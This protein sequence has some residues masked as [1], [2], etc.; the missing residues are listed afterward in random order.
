MIGYRFVRV[1]AA[2][3]VCATAIPAPA[4]SIN[5]DFD[6]ASG[7]GAGVPNAA[8]GGAAS[9]SGL[10]NSIVFTFTNPGPFALAD[11]S[12]APTTATVTQSGLIGSINFSQSATNGNYKLLID[13]AVFATAA[14]TLRIDGLQ[15]GQYTVY[16]YAISPTGSGGFER[17]GIS[18]TGSA[19][20]SPQSIGGPIP[21]GT[22]ANGLTHAIHNVYVAAGSPL[23]I[24]ASPWGGNGYINGM[25][26]V[27]AI[28]A[29]SDI[30]YPVEGSCV[31]GTVNVSGTAS[32]IASYSL[33]Y[34]TQLS[35]P[36]FAISSRTT[37]VTNATLGT[38]NTA[39]LDEGTYYLR[40][41]TVTPNG[42]SSTLVR[43]VVVTR[44]LPT[45][46]LASPK[47]NAV[48]GGRVPVSGSANDICLASYQ[49][50]YIDVEGLPT[51]HV[52]DPAAP[53]S[54]ASVSGGVLGVW[55]TQSVS[56]GLY[57]LRLRVRD[58]CNNS[59]LDFARVSVDNTPPILAMM[60]PDTI[61][62]PCRA[63]SVV[64][65]VYDEH[66]DGW[67]LEYLSDRS[68]QWT[69]LASGRGTVV[70]ESLAEWETRDLAPGAYTLRLRA[71]DFSQRDGVPGNGN[72]ASLTMSVLLGGVGDVNNDGLVN[73][74][75]LAIVLA[76]FGSACN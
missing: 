38:W 43:R 7:S 65:T 75:D 52:I 44:N 22:F 5:I 15:S 16:T 54:G 11:I 32:N 35:G 36:W 37:P 71:T 13:D 70:N 46:D 2:A 58:N 60:M 25:Q 30:S 50:T 39:T 12:G 21:A 41:T 61:V 73:S 20:P 56:D 45:A 62:E 64:G 48:V 74:A 24:T 63:L 67:S 10:W 14:Y 18:V 34:C 57:D 76:R 68:A 42:T 4:Q 17:N 8:Y 51:E 47:A 72:A 55:D 1:A 49:V 27:R 3:V 28:A 33:D 9:Q 26:I 53:T 23:V 66:L 31:C 59:A 19:S 29:L 40:L 69:P 6:G